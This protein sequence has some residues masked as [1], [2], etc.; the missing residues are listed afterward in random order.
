MLILQKGSFLG[1]VSQIK[2]ENGATVSVTNYDCNDAEANSKHYHEH[3]NLYFV[4]KGGSIEKKGIYEKELLSGSLQFYYSGEHHQNTRT[5]FPSESI[6]LEI[7][8]STIIKYHLTEDK[9]RDAVLQSPSIRFLMLKILKELN[10]DDKYSSM[11]INMLVLNIINQFE[12]KRIYNTAPTWIKQLH[13]LLNDC[14]DE[15]LSLSYL[16]KIVNVHP[17]TISKFFPVY[18]QCTLG[19]YMRH[20][21]ICRAIALIKNSNLPLTKIAYSCGFADQ[22]HF[23][24]TF[25]DCTGFNPKLYRKM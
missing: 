5:N 20:L 21:K 14:W 4:L 2:S 10:T 1:N 7:E 25:K 12:K 6:N 16:S 22:S 23:T 17:V 24:R 18:F 9:I 8:H 3:P 15:N 13:L 11:T 19:E